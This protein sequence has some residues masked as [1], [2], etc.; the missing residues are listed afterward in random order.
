M[1]SA[2]FFHAVNVP[3]SL[4]LLTALIRRLILLFIRVGIALCI[5]ADS[6]SAYFGQVRV[7][8][9]PVDRNGLV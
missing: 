5:V 6:Q 8:G 3:L 1:A 9:W 2:V 7:C 4:I